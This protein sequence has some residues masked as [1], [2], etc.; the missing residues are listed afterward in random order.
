M[1]EIEKILM[2]RRI[3]PFDRL[4]GDELK[5]IA[6]IGQPYTYSPGQTIEA[7]GNMPTKL[8]I[9]PPESVASEIPGII[10]LKEI[11]TGRPFSKAVCAGE[12]P[13]PSIIVNKSFVY[14]ILFECPEMI[15]WVNETTVFRGAS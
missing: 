4:N 9:V 2:L 12:E 11:I 8:T 1:S 13:L 14:T 10:G 3:A 6:S 5:V 7:K 15:L